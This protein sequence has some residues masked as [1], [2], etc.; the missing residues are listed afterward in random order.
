MTT[1]A[2]QETVVR[3]DQDE[4][5]LYLWT[6]Y[7]AQARKWTRLGYPV[8]V[9]GRTRTGDPRSWEARAPVEALRF[10]RLEGGKVVSRRR[11]R[12]I[13]SASRKLAGESEPLASGQP[14]SD[15]LAESA[16]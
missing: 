16:N 10:R 12:S 4:R 7:P 13:A 8:K 9:H 15:A 14:P 5:V 3:W 6:A 1:K 11:G 2:E